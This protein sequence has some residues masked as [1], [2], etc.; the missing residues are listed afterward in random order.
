MIAS[1]GASMTI[2]RLSRPGVASKSNFGITGPAK[3]RSCAVQ[4]HCHR[5]VW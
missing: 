5:I 3:E 4:Y 1:G 2:S